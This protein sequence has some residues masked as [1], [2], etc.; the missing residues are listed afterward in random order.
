MRTISAKRR[1]KQNIS[2][3]HNV[4]SEG[5]MIWVGYNKEDQWDANRGELILSYLIKNFKLDKIGYREN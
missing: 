1:R 3:R 2:T 5:L 4:S